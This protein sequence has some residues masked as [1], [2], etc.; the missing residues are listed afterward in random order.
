MKKSKRILR[1]LPWFSLILFLG[2]GGVNAEPIPGLFNTGVNDSGVLLS[3]GAV[4]AHWQLMQSADGSYPGPNAYVVNDGWPIQSGVWMLNGPDSKWISARADQNQQV[5]SAYGNQPG[6]YVFRITCDLTGLEPSTAV[7][8]GQWSSD[9]AGIDVRLNGVST[10]INSDG[11]F[12]AWTPMFTIDSGFQEGVNVL[13]FV[14]NNAGTAVNPLG[15]RAELSGTADPGAPPGTPPSILQ[16]PES[17]EAGQGSAVSFN[18]RVYGSRPFSYQWR[19]NGNPISGANSSTLTVPSVG[20]AD[21]GDYDVVVTNEFGAD[22]SDVAMLSLVYLSPAQLTYEP[23]GPSSRRTGLVFSEIMYHPAN[24]ADGRNVEFIEIYNSNPFF[25]DLSGYRLSGEVD[26]TF[27]VGTRIEGLSYLV[28]APAPQDV[29]ATYGIGGVVGGFTNR[30][31]NSGGTLRLQKKSDAIVLDLAYSD[32]P[33]WPVAADGTGHS[34]V[35]ARPSYGERNPKAWEASALV[36]GSPGA[37]D[38]VPS[39][40]LENLVINEILAHTDLPLVDYVELYNHSPLAVNVGGCWLSDNRDTNKFQIPPDTMLPPR[41]F[42][43]YDEMELGFGLSADG[44]T[45]YL[46]SPDQQRVLDVLRFDGQAN[47]IAFGRYPDGAEGFQELTERT[48]GEPNAP[49]LI[50]DVEIN[51]IMYHPISQD[52]DDEFVELYNRGENPVDVGGWRFMDGIDYAFPPGTSIAADGYLVVARNASRLL[53]NY[54]GLDPLIVFGDYGGSLSDAGERIRLGMP[55][56]ILE[57]NL[58]NGTILTN[59]FFVVVDEVTY[60]D[61]G[62]WGEWADGGGSSL[63]LIDPR[64]DN[65]LPTNWRD[66]DETGKAPWTLVEHT[67]VL[68]NGSGTASPELQIHLQAAGEALVDDVEVFTEG[69]ANRIA[70]GTF[71]SGPSGW[72]FQGN[73]RHTSLETSEGYHSAQSLHVRATD[74]GDTINRV[75]APFTSAFTAGPTGTIRAQVRW[76]RGLPEILLRMKENYLEAVGRLEVP[77]NLGTPG[78]ANSMAVANA[79]PAITAVTHRPALPAANQPIRVL[80]RVRDTDGVGSVV[81][82]YRIDPSTTLTEIPMMDDGSEGDL[83]AGDGIYAAVIPAQP[84]STLVAFRVEAADAADIPAGSQFPADAPERECLVRF[85]EFVPAG[86]LGSYRLWMTRA[87]FDFWTSREKMSN[88]ALDTTF[89]YGNYRVIYNT[90]SYFAGSA[91]SSPGYTTPSGVL[92]GY[93]VLYPDDEPFLG[94]NHVILDWPNRDSTF[95]REHTMYWLLDQAGL[96]NLYRRN[97]HLFVNGARRGTL[98]NDAQQPGGDIIEEWFPNHAEGD[99]YKTSFYFEFN[100][101]G[102]RQGGTPNTLEQFLT[103]GGEKKTA[104]YRWCW[105]PRT[106]HGSANDFAP[107]FELVDALN[108]P[109]GSYLPAVEH[110]VDVENWMRTFAGNDLASYWDAFG[111]PNYKNTYLYKPKG[112]GW[113]LICWDFD[114]GLGTGNG[115]GQYQ[116]RYDAALFDTANEQAIARM[117]NT[118]SIVR[119]YWAALDE[120]VHSFFQPSAVQEFLANRYAAYQAEGISTDSPF[121]PTGQVPSGEPQRSI[122]DWITVRRNFILGELAKVDAAFAVNGPTELTVD[123][124]LIT[125]GGSAPVA[126]KTITVNSTAYPVTWTTVSN[127]TVRVVLAAG[128]NNLTIEGMDRLGNPVVGASATLSATFTGADVSPVDVVV[129]NEIMY[130]PLVPGS[131]FIEL[132]NTST[133]HSFDLSGWRLNGLD[134]T[135]PV[136]SVITNGQYLVLAKNTIALVNSLGNTVAV[137]DEFNGTLANDGETLTLSMPGS[138]PGEEIVVDR[139]TY[140]NLPPWPSAANGQGPSIQLIDPLQDNNRAS[141]WSDGQ[142]WRFFSFTRTSGFQTSSRLSFF[143]N[144]EIGDV[145]LDDVALV[146]GDVPGAGTNL[147]TNPGFEDGF[148][149]WGIGYVATNSVLVTNDAHSGQNS[150]HVIFNPAGGG[151]PVLTAFYQDIPDVTQYTTYTLSFWYK[152]GAPGHSFRARLNSTFYPTLPMEVMQ[153][154]PG[155]ANIGTATLPAYPLLWLSEV[156]PNNQNTAWDNA[157]EAD[158]WIEIHNGSAAPISLDGMVLSDQ[159]TDPAAWAFPA[160]AELQPNE[161]RV[162]W[163]DGSPAQSD[164][165]NWHANF[166]L[167]PTNGTVY[168]SRMLSG[169]PQ[170]LDYLH[171]FGAEADQSFGAY[172]PNQNSYREWFYYPTPGDTNNPSTPLVTLFINEWLAANLGIVLDPADQDSDDW[173]EI[174][175]PNDQT[176]DLAGY[177]LTDNPGSPTKYVIPGGFE[178]APHGFLLVWADEEGSQTSPLGRLHVNFRLSASGESISLYAPD[179]RLVDAVTFG[180]Q[181]DNVS[182]GRFPDGSPTIES[183]LTSPTPGGPNLLTTPPPEVSIL[184]VEYNGGGLTL[185]WAAQAGRT[186]RVQYKSDLASP[187]WIDLPGDINASVETASKT[188]PATE[189]DAQRF[190]RVVL[191]E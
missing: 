43:H 61:G 54:P 134:Y 175:N 97:I 49:I 41:G 30:L 111:N 181:T 3:G 146:E 100:D 165:V 71:E 114:V 90:G 1:S 78:A 12:G 4:D 67:G 8:T 116:E 159:L 11:N 153:A 18:V 88:E 145:Y 173:F 74:R 107:L 132:Y 29:Q 95:L 104:R 185:T 99:L 45:V 7:I 81:V 182:Q 48:P 189:G 168:L 39:G 55:D 127:W 124:N 190:Y 157:G 131:S 33:P 19:L 164:A 120:A 130:N 125:L 20:A 56:S 93:D 113:K 9:N 152:T 38:P 108:S 50:R 136:G 126:V 178:I 140:D 34:M 115:G 42:L 82:R 154:T 163:A 105:K 51:E 35:L 109:A 47:A 187:D 103:T 135:F 128:E 63:E 176:V 14:V 143:F 15:F 184:E 158:P 23:L 162:I 26:Y 166:R 85:G 77:A 91:W 138:I 84:N 46:W 64:S 59:Y 160:G 5:N 98:Y 13:D 66:S 44:E 6:D 83:V 150:A 31:A 137:F 141:N 133:T 73:Q 53:T 172:P 40:P 170:I 92:C 110:V 86:S 70:N 25:E 183:A 36:G 65:R 52:N 32:Q 27:P 171:Y 60:A 69:G 147:L 101:A 62:Q 155:A 112:A 24:R 121:V 177:T 142:G 117:N 144:N 16:H 87:T 58:A 10:G 156:Q 167:N 118:P 179:G 21:A 96:P 186:Y 129:I 139:V 72:F 106:I 102:V 75:R 119:H 149:S 151:T 80:A 68:D 28:V 188:D 89:V 180:T 148:D 76:L 169:S 161:Y 37:P 17:V 2:A 123:T 22:T 79:G 191:L 122:P 57:T 174:Y 94:D